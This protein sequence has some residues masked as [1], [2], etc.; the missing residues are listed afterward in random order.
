VLLYL[1]VVQLG[2]AYVL[3]IGGV[4]KVPAAEASLISM[5]EPILNP[6]WVLLGT[7]ERPGPWAI[8]GAVIVVA[9]VVTRTLAPAAPERV[10][11]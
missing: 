4:R 6:I 7:G 8:A 5:L 11:T 3:F 2:L 9:A 10:P 1:G